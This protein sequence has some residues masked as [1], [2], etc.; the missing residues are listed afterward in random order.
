MSQVCALEYDFRRASADEA[1][2]DVRAA[3]INREVIKIKRQD[4]Q[5][6]KVTEKFDRRIGTANIEVTNHADHYR[7]HWVALQVLGKV[8]DKSDPCLR[9]LNDADAVKLDVSTAQNLL[10]QSTVPVS[11]IWGDF[12]FVEAVEDSR[13]Q[14]FYDDG[15]WPQFEEGNVLMMQLVRRVHWFRSSAVHTRWEEEVR[16]LEEEMRRTLRFYAYHRAQWE[17]RAQ[18]RTQAQEYGAAAYARK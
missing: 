1:L 15:K 7:R 16:L 2:R 11:W 12:R 13:Y 9:R 18:N 4:S 6:K 14:E 5:T 3:I 8:L 17:D 10:G